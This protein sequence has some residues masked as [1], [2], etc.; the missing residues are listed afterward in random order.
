MDSWF[1]LAVSV[2]G[3]CLMDLIDLIISDLTGCFLDYD[4]AFDLL[5]LHEILL[6]LAARL[7]LPQAFTYC[8]SNLYLRLRREVKFSKGL[9]VSTL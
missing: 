4:K 2:K 3:L 7:G 1:T 5:P 6:P 9:V 8:L